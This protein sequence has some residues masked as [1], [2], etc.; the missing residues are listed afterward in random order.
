GLRAAGGD[1]RVHAGN[2]EVALEAEPLRRVT[3]DPRAAEADLR[4]PLDVEEV[5]RAQV[6]VPL[7]VA[8]LDGRRVDL[9]LDPRA[10]RVLGDV[11]VARYTVELAP[12]LDHHQVPSR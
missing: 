1:G 6:L 12:Y 2:G 8:A 11:D 7:G 5:G 9:D 3:L 4:V 10:D